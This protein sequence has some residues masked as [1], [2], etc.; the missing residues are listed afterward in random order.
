MALIIGITMRVVENTSYYERRDAISQEWFKY[1][2]RELPDRIIFP[3]ANQPQH[4]HTIFK[5]IKFEGLILSGGNDYGEAPERDGT[6]MSIINHCLI[7]NIPVLGVCRGLHV[8]NQY[9]GGTLETRLVRLSNI[10]HTGSNHSVELMDKRF[11]IIK[12]VQKKIRV[13][14]YHNQGVMLN[15]LGHDLI[16][17]AVDDSGVVEGLFHS[18]H[19]IL[20]VQWH[21]ERNNPSKAFDESLINLLF[22]KGSFWN[23]KYDNCGDNS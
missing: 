9:F 14:S 22:S 3:I 11:Q 10:L 2:H 16:P 5:S 23:S 18:T 7:E 12:P 13:N 20:A 8:I 15:N 21:P 1:L 19:P 4:V 6:E 17:F